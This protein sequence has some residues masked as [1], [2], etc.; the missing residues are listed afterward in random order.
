MFHI[1]AEKILVII[2]CHNFQIFLIINP[3][4]IIILKRSDSITLPPNNRR[5]MEEVRIT[6]SEIQPIA[7]RFLKP[8]NLL[9]LSHIVLLPKILAQI[10]EKIVF[11]RL[12]GFVNTLNLAD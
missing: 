9:L 8:Q 11:L 6:I 7:L 5:R 3:I 1:L 10:D 2:N 12:Q 4:I